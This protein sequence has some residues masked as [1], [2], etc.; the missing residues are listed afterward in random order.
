VLREMLLRLRIL[1][2]L[3]STRPIPVR[4]TPAGFV[5]FG[6]AVYGS[7]DEF[8]EALRR[9]RPKDARVLPDR[10]ADFRQVSEV[11][12]AFQVAKVGTY[13]GFKG[14]ALPETSNTGSG[15]DSVS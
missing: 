6:G 4:L 13:L 15:G 3:R 5:D 10:D 12:R 7:F 9:I 2:R 11:L 8:V 1:L 14:N